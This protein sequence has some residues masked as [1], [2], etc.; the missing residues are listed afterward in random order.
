MHSACH[1][2][3]AAHGCKGSSASVT[4]CEQCYERLQDGRFIV[5]VLIESLGQIKHSTRMS[6]CNCALLFRSHSANRNGDA[7]STVFIQWIWSDCNCARIEFVSKTLGWFYLSFSPSLHIHAEW[8]SPQKGEKCARKKNHLNYYNQ[9]IVNNEKKRCNFL[10]GVF[11]CYFVVSCH[12]YVSAMHHIW[13][14]E[15]SQTLRALGGVWLFC[16][17]H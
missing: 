17:S 10:N 1:V 8:D 3:F 7:I 6:L 15:Y 11:L 16:R 5:L 2:D 9:T 13:D 4:M 14:D 12:G